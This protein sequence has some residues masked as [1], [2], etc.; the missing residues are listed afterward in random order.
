MTATPL[1]RLHRVAVLHSLAAALGRVNTGQDRK[2]TRLNSSHGYIPYA[3]FCLI[4]KP[5]G[6]EDGSDRPSPRQNYNDLLLPYVQYSFTQH[7]A[8]PW[9]A[10]SAGGHSLAEITPLRRVAGR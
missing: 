6:R 2:S 5:A 1:P 4:K 9:P 10:V 3:V 8:P 7:F